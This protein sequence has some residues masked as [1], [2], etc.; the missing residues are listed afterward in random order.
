[1][2][3][4]G[5]NWRMFGKNNGRMDLLA[6]LQIQSVNVPKGPTAKL[7]AGQV[8]PR[9]IEPPDSSTPS[10]TGDIQASIV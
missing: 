10:E 6:L 7:L 8:S 2:T 1:M 3:P 4:R 5:L 9:K